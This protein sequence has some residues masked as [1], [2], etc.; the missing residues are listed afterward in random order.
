MIVKSNVSSVNQVK[1]NNTKL[2]LDALKTIPFGTKNTVS[3][4]TGLSIATCNT[5]LNEL[6]ETKKVFEVAGAYSPAGRPPKSYKFNAD[7]SHICCLYVTHEDHQQMIHYSIVNLLGEI[8][9]SNSV[10]TDV[11][12]GSTIISTIEERI[13]C[14]P[15]ISKISTGIPGY[16]CDGKVSAVCLP[17]LSGFPLKEALK[18]HFHMEVHCDNDMNIIALGLFKEMFPQMDDPFAIIG[19]FKGQ[20]PG[21]GTIVHQKIVKGMSNFAGEVLHLKASDPDFWYD[22]SSH[23][24]E[25]VEK[26]FLITLGFIT[27]INPRTIVLTGKNAA[28]NMAE[29]LKKACR[30]HLAEEHIPELMYIEDIAPYYIRGLFGKTEM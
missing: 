29:D 18:E 28:G 2:I 30:E 3:Q 14:D 11:I 13:A 8:L 15:L 22:I 5:I 16:L 24:E 12:D 23:Y 19:F 17:E 7:Y 27:I 9:E 26:A 1:D 4:I 10:N 6:S 20:G 25:A 21:A